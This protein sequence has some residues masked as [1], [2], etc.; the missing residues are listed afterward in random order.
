M[1]KSFISGNTDFY[2]RAFKTYENTLNGQANSEIHKIRKTAIQNFVNLGYPSKKNEEWK[3]TD[4]SD[5]ARIDF[6]P[7]VNTPA[8]KIK[9]SDIK[10][11]QFTDLDCHLLVFVNGR[12]VP[13][14]SSHDPL[15]SGIDIKPLDTALK[16]DDAIINSSITRYANFEKESFT[17]LNTA[18]IQDG[19]CIKVKD[20]ITVKKPIH[21]LYLTR[22]D[23]NNLLTHPRN[24]FIAG[25]NS[26]LKLIETYAGLSKEVYFTNSVTEIILDSHAQID[27]LKVQLESE[28]AYHI[29]MT[30]VQQSRGSEYTSHSFSIGGGLVRNN[31]HVVLDA[32]GCET[33][34]NGLYVANQNQHVDNHTSVDHSKPHCNSHE[35]YRGILDDNARGV[36]NGKIYVHPNAQKT[37]A[38]Q[39]NNCILLSD[40]ANIDTKPQLEIY[41]DDVKCTHG[42]TIGQLDE[43]AF[44]YMR[45]RGIEK[46][47]ARNLLI[48]A[49]ASDVINRIPDGA[50]RERIA[51]LFADKLHTSKPV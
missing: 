3:Y 26:R 35:L 18:F 31:I 39:A 9:S 43:D 38:I 13:E 29:A 22:A 25:E 33:T 50:I 2:L 8:K 14:L 5:L 36:F 40:G 32:E 28:S 6:N 20:G 51:D 16:D 34:L 41:A 42:A 11:Y 19:A 37:N 21:L 44:F 15:E 10:Q 23:E 45:S 49:F 24:L 27:H 4:I 47:K 7:A 17:A 46:T 48:Y 30:Q 1:G 12:F